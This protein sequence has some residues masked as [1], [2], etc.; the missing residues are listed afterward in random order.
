MKNAEKVYRLKYKSMYMYSEI[1]L[2]EKA[3]TICITGKLNTPKM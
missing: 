2:K 1:I 3:L